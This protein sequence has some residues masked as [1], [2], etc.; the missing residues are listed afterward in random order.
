MKP[1]LRW[2]GGKQ[3]LARTLL[4]LVPD[5]DGTYYEPFLGGGSLF[6]ALRPK[7]A[8]LG[9]INGRLTETYQVVRDFPHELITILS[10]WVNDDSTYYAVRPTEFEDA[11]SR[12]AQVI[13]LNKTC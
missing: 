2:A 12:A 3:W 6:F 1:F 13:Y 8:V 10:H 11:L 7:R 5:N 4:A 9:D